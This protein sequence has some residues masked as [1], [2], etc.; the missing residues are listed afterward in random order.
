MPNAF[1]NLVCVTRSHIPAANAPANMDV[2]NRGRP[3]GSK[4]SHPWKRKPTTRGPEEPTMNP[5]IAYSFYPSHKEIL[6][7]GSVFEETNL[8]PRIHLQ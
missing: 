5:T 1:T 6:D 7:Y 4:N 2:P 8:L 3:P